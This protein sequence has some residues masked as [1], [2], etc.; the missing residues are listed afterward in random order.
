MPTP[1]ILVAT[2]DNWLFSV[3]R[4]MACGE[5]AG[6]SVGGLAADGPTILRWRLEFVQW[7]RHAMVPCC[8]PKSM[9]AA[10]RDK[11]IPAYA[12]GL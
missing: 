10:F 12:G 8:W 4:K 6:Q 11:R 2:W 9:S 1:T 7:R 3:T 5:L